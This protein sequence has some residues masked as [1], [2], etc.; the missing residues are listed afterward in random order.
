MRTADAE[1]VKPLV[2]DG[3]E[4]AFLDVREHGQ[5][6]LCQRFFYRLDLTCR[7]LL[8]EKSLRFQDADVL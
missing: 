4:I 5:F 1:A 6:T 3:G 7:I 8:I 2:T